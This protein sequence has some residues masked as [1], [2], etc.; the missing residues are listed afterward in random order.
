MSGQKI[1]RGGWEVQR[2]VAKW[3]KKN[4]LFMSPFTSMCS[5]VMSIS[6]LRQELSR[7]HIKLKMGGC[8][9]ILKN[10]MTKM[11]K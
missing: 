5:I 3:Q 9:P 7:I 1:G 6:T 11:K 10:L 8:S 2:L 4:C